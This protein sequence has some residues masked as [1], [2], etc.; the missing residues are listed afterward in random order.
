LSRLFGDPDYLAPDNRGIT[1][2]VNFRKFWE[3]IIKYFILL[4][5]LL[6]LITNNNNNNNNK[7]RAR[8]Y[9]SNAPVSTVCITPTMKR[10]LYSQYNI[11]VEKAAKFSATTCI[12]TATKSYTPDFLPQH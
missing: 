5:L 2:Y 7:R 3:N 1:V 11:T 8:R 10:K 6:Q 4:L 9:V 12:L